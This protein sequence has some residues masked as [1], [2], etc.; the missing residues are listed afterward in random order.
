MMGAIDILKAL[1]YELAAYIVS[2]LDVRTVVRMSA[3]SRHWRALSRDNAYWRQR[4]AEMNWRL[5]LSRQLD[6]HDD[7]RI[8]WHYFYKQKYQLEQRWN[9]GRVVSHNFIGH[10]SSVYCVQFDD[11]KLVTGS[12]DWTIK[13]W[14]LSTYQCR[15]TLEGHRGSVLCLKYNDHIMVSGSSD[16]TV[17]VW[18]MYHLQKIRRLKVI[19]DSHVA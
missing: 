1:P 14:D 15:A 5:Q 18:S 7:D 3:V 12:R 9:L 2:F 17:I 6:N 13:V 10:K 16:T 8:E 4:M 19:N 11:R